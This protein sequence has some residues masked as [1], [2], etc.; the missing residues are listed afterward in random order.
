MTVNRY[1]TQAGKKYEKDLLDY[2]RAHNFDTER[3]RLAG[4]EDE[5]DLLLRTP[6]PLTLANTPDRF[7]LEAKR[8][9]GFNLA[10]WVKEARVEAD[11]Y[12]E[13][14]GLMTP[15]GFLVV[16][17]ARGKGIG[18]SYVTTTLEEWLSWL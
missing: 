12:A 10:S 9:K 6:V 18:Q 11:N 15:P 2:F 4:A 13:H 7:V 14:R 5:G 16:H 17:A 1:A 3:L 8:E